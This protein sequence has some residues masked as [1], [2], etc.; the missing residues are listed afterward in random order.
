MPG[1]LLWGLGIPFFAA[2]LIFHERHK[3]DSLATRQ[4]YG[5]LFRGYKKKY[6]FWES[7]IMYRKTILIFVS[8]FFVGYGVIVQALLILLL[9]IFGV[10]K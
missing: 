9:L 3:L 1:L 10:T 7:V 5:F 6:Y 4:K 8:V 2:Q